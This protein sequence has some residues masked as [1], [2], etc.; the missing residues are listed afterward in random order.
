MSLSMQFQ[1]TNMNKVK[2]Q[3]N[4]QLGKLARRAARKI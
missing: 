1:K 4:P 3:Q 2:Q